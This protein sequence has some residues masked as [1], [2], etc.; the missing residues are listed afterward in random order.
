MVAAIFNISS[1]IYWILLRKLFKFG[2]YSR[3]E[4]I[5]GITVYIYSPFSKNSTYDWNGPKTWTK[6]Q[7]VYTAV[8]FFIFVFWTYLYFLA[9]STLNNDDKIDIEELKNLAKEKCMKNP[10]YK[11]P[12]WKCLKPTVFDVS[13]WYRSDSLCR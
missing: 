3:A 12:I 6:A 9:T 7:I 8:S 4:T 10:N 5:W 13:L 11:M 1:L 2:N